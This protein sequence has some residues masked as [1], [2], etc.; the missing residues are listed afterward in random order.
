MQFFGFT[1]PELLA[2]VA[3]LEEENLIAWRDEEIELTG[4]AHEC[5]ERVGEKNMPRF[6]DISDEVDRVSFDLLDYRLIADRVAAKPN[7]AN[8]EL[9][10]P[11]ESFEGTADKARAAFDEKF[12]DFLEKIKKVDV[13][14]EH[15][16]LYKINSVSPDD[17]RMLPIKVECILES[18]ESTEPVFAYADDWL[19]EWDDERKII[20]AI[21]RDLVAQKVSSSLLDDG[22]RQ[23]L[24]T[25]SAFPK[26]GRPTKSVTPDTSHLSVPRA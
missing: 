15:R 3:D 26:A 4:Y 12:S 19:N 2:V 16:E 5:F 9:R 21:S 1:T 22:A 23:S 18:A 24:G 13:F 17:D 25:R 14:N 10:L 7:P 6:F 8:V 11:K 20:G